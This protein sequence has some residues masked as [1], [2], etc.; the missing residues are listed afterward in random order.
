MIS[1][2]H[3]SAMRLGFGADLFAHPL[4]VRTRADQVGRPVELARTSTARC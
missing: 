2:N 4:H 1:G 3:D